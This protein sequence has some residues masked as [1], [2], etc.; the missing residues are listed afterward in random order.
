MTRII[1]LAL[2]LLALPLMAACGTDTNAPEP[3]NVVLEGSVFQFNTPTVTIQVG[4]PVT[5][6]FVNKGVIDHALAIDEW[7][8]ET[9][10]LRPGESAELTFTSRETGTFSFYCAVPG[11]TAAGMTGTFKV[12]P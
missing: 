5:L 7:N 12:T 4:Q 8:L 3:L 11:H 6:H 10:V 9:E 1:R 2:L